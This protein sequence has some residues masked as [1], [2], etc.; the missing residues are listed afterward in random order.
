MPAGPRFRCDMRR[1]LFRRGTTECPRLRD[2]GRYPRR[3]LSHCRHKVDTPDKVPGRLC[4]WSNCRC[5]W[6]VFVSVPQQSTPRLDGPA[7]RSNVLCLLPGR[8]VCQNLVVMSKLC[9]RHRP[10]YHPRPVR[11]HK[12]PSA[13]TRAG[14][15]REAAGEGSASRGGELHHNGTHWRSRLI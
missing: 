8:E 6:R 4:Q 1:G 15:A 12:N 5:A 10:S 2:A 14:G 7:G 11:H 3:K 13:W 9:H